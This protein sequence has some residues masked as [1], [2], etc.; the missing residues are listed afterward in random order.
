[1]VNRSEKYEMK[2]FVG[3]T[4]HDW[5]ALLFTTATFSKAPRQSAAKTAGKKDGGQ[6]SQRL[7]NLETKSVHLSLLCEMRTPSLQKNLIPL[8][9]CS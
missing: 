1:M 3:V 2:E 9:Y 6:A 8:P 5:C 4:D 7:V